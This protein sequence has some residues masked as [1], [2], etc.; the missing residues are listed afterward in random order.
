[1]PK[2]QFWMYHLS[3]GAEINKEL[4]E[5]I[6]DLSERKHPAAAPEIVTDGVQQQQ[7]FMGCTLVAP[8]PYIQFS[9]AINEVHHTMC[10]L[11]QINLMMHYIDRAQQR[12]L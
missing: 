2:R 12:P 8:F 6:L 7:R 1:M 9:E 5:R 11:Y 4:S 3:I 10:I